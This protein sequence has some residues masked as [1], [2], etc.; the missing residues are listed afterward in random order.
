MKNAFPDVTIGF[1][2]DVNAAAVGEYAHSGLNVNSLAY[3]T[4]GTGI[5]VGA[6]IDGRPVHGLTHPETGHILVRKRPGDEEF[7]GTC[8]YHGDCLEG[9]A[10]AGAIASVR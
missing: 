10:S 9:V 6:V 8:P 4:V 2:T 1:D 5:G 3:V 7:M